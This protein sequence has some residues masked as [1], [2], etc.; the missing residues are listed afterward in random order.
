M[1]L[2]KTGALIA[3]RRK[4][5]ALTQKE[6]ARILG[7]TDK[8]VSRWE[9]G[10]GFPDPAILQPLAAALDLSVTQLVSGEDQPEPISGQQADDAVLSAF[11]YARQQSSAVSA[12]LLGG[13]GI[14]VLLL[15][16]SVVGISPLV[17]RIAA[18]GLLLAAFA[19]SWGSWL[20][21]KL[22]RNLAAA[23]LAGALALEFVPGSAVMIFAAGPDSRITKY[24]SCFLDMGLLWGYAMILPAL[25]A[26]LTAVA[27]VMMLALLI[28]KKQMLAGKIYVCTI[29]GAVLM[30]AT[31]VLMG[32]EYI[33]WVGM[34]IVFLLAVSAMLQARANS[35]VK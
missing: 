16:Q 33:S 35:E 22:A 27:A 13:A 3:G 25:G 8:A 34:L 11:S 7:V 15:S 6:L 28:G 31:P 1:D 19:R 17:M 4:E 2:K 18:A 26:I 32:S 14:L 10:K 21:R 24:V 29:A 12:S 30:L 9:T 5:K 23:A 20:T